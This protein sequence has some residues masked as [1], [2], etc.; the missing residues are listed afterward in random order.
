MSAAAWAAMA[1]WWAAMTHRTPS[2]LASAAA[3]LWALE[4][5]IAAWVLDARATRLA[6]EFLIVLLLLLGTQLRSSRLREFSRSVNC[7]CFASINVR[8]VSFIVR[9]VGRFVMRFIAAVV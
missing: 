9:R 3:A 4:P 6:I 1:L 7:F 8:V 2:A 5:C